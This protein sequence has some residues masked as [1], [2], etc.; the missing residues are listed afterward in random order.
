MTI[1]IK[2]QQN[3][4]HTLQKNCH[5]NRTQINTVHKNNNTIIKSNRSCGWKYISSKMGK[6][7]LNNVLIYKFTDA[8]SGSVVGMN[9]CS[10]KLS[11]CTLQISTTKFH[12]CSW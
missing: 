9:L 2:G 1:N 11:L 10:M 6:T 4:T 7:T 5:S 3:L 12:A 8:N